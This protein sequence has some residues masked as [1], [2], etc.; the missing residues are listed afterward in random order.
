MTLVGLD[1]IQHLLHY[2][3]S[4]IMG[5]VTPIMGI[6]YIVRY[7]MLTR[8]FFLQASSRFDEIEMVI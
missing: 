1:F 5:I 3:Y 7:P 4:P 6:F 8:D 2:A